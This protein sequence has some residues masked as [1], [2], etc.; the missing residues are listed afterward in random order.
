[1]VR[2]TIDPLARRIHF[3]INTLDHTETPLEDLGM[4]FL[5]L[6]SAAI[7]MHPRNA[8]ILIE[9]TRKRDDNRKLHGG[10]RAP[11]AAVHHGAE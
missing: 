1:M 7:K 9:R 3:R 5:S 8:H 6:D 4:I 2:T 11:S 10:V